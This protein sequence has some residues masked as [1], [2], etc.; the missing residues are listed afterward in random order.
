MTLGMIGVSEGG[1]SV[2]CCWVLASAV[3]GARVVAI[4]RRVQ[5]RNPPTKATTT[6]DGGA[7]AQRLQ[8]SRLCCDA[9]VSAEDNTHRTNAHI[10]HKARARAREG[11]TTADMHK[12]ASS[13]YVNPRRRTQAPATVVTRNMGLGATT[14][15]SLVQLCLRNAGRTYTYTAP[16][17]AR[18]MAQRGWRHWPIQ[19]RTS[20]T[21]NSPDSTFFSWAPSGEKEIARTRPDAGCECEAVKANSM[22]AIP[23]G[24][25]HVRGCIRSFTH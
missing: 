1:R 11:K 17:R 10:Q 18:P 2:N 4:A 21:V 8:Q 5:S 3:V 16:L 13:V 20:L 22:I 14:A 23:W 15:F 24:H 7:M 25:Q 12:H 19:E 6:P 9:A